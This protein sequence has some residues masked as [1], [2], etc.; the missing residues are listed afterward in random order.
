MAESDG[1]VDCIEEVLD[2]LITE[3]WPRHC[4]ASTV[5]EIDAGEFG[6]YEPKRT[7]FVE[8]IRSAALRRRLCHDVLP[9]RNHND[10][11]Q[12]TDRITKQ[13]Y[14]GQ[15]LIIS[16][17][18]TESWNHLH[19]VH[20]C[21]WNAGTCRCNAFRG[22]RFIRRRRAKW[23]GELHRGKKQYIFSILSPHVFAF[24]C[25][26][27]YML[28][29]T[30]DIRD[31]GI[32]MF[33]QPR[34]CLHYF[35]AGTR[36]EVPRPDEIDSHDGSEEGPQRS[37]VDENDEI[38]AIRRISFDDG[39]K[40][41]ASEPSKKRERRSSKSPQFKKNNKTQKI[42]QFF[43]NFPVC[44][45]LSACKTVQWLDDNEL[46][47]IGR[48]DA[49]F[50]AAI[51]IFQRQIC[52]KSI[53]ELIEFYLHCQPLFDCTSGHVYDFYYSIEES[54]AKLQELLMFQSNYHSNLVEEFLL[55]VY[56][57]LDR[58]EEKKNCLQI[59]GPSNGGKTLFSKICASLC[60]VKG[61]I[62]NFN[63]Y[64]QFPLQDCVDKR[65]L[66]WDEPNCEPAAFDTCK[67]LFAGD[68]TMANIKYQS[69]VQIDKTPI[70]I[71]TNT[72]VFPNNEVF[73]NRMYKYTWQTALFL[74]DFKKHLHPLALY[75]LW[76][77]YGIIISNS[78]ETSTNVPLDSSNILEV[79][80]TD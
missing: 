13:R 69:H 31:L 77:A 35:C 62:A 20:D 68:P 58:R 46:C 65:I 57:V 14:Y 42:V 3:H 4:P 12:I 21:S 61:Q 22:L 41:T 32:Y 53:N 75:E 79:R 59:K 71:T 10:G 44:P 16:Y 64:C 66:I 40:P 80:S 11:R 74:K 47:R 7:P 19:V 49:E 30:D 24:C 27:K 5:D 28:V 63:K 34:F 56:N 18:E 17:H 33:L 39:K 78:N 67:M 25:K 52:N 8:L 48:N 26:L 72:D 76:K 6:I 36:R 23:T 55:V 1:N 60:L 51:D 73:N 38:C 50:I 15:L 37:T 70:I 9:V 54:T 2:D 29:F 45:L 43:Q